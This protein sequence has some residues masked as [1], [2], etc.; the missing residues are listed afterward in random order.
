MVQWGLEHCTFGEALEQ[1]NLG[2]DIVSIASLE[3][4]VPTHDLLTFVAA[5]RP[6]RA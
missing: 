6:T 1:Y 5:K 4:T 3:D 2:L